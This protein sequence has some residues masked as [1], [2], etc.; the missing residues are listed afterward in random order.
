WNAQMSRDQVGVY[1]LE[2]PLSGT[3][4]QR[5]LGRAPALAIRLAVVPRPDA[6]GMTEVRVEVRPLRCPRDRAAAVLASQAPE[7]LQSLRSFLNALPERRTLPRV[8]FDQSLALYPVLEGR[9]LGDP[10]VCQGK[11]LSLQ[12]LGLISPQSPPSE[13]VYIQSMM[14]AEL[15]DLALLGQV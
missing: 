6:K 3:F 11:D 5:C 10:L 14:T 13:R 15:A 12:G 9:E 7:L 8:P 4:W 1:E 2:V